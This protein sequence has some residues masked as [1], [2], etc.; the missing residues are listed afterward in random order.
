MFRGG[1]SRDEPLKARLTIFI[2]IWSQDVS[3]LRGMAKSPV[4]HHFLVNVAFLVAAHLHYVTDYR[5]NISTP[6]GLYVWIMTIN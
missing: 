6:F 5:R 3:D 4:A 1:G 2:P